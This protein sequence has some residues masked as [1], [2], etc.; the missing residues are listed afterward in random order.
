MLAFEVNVFGKRR[1]LA[2][3]HLLGLSVA[4]IFVQGRDGMEQ[5][6]PGC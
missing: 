6:T 4:A 5:W 3:F 2:G 1:R